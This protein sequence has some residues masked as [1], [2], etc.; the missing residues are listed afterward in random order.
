MTM[1]MNLIQ[2]AENLAPLLR[3]TAREAELNR[4][5]LDRVIDAIRESGLF[6]LMVPKQYGGFEADLDTFFEVVL[7]LSRAD[8]SMGWITGFYIEHN[9][10]LC[11]YSEDVCKKVYDG[12]NHVLAPATLNIGAGKATKVDGGYRL[13]GQW[14]WGTGIVHGSWVMAG[15]LVMDETTGPVPTFFLLPLAD[16]EPIDTWHVT[17]MCATGSWDFKIN[18]VFVPDDHALPFLQFLTATSGIAER[19]ESPLYSTPLMP[20]LGFAAALPIL[21]TAQMALTEFTNQVKQKIESNATRSGTPLQ[22]VSGVIGEVAL[23]LEAAELV[24]RNVLK[25]VMEKRNNASPTEGA[26]WLSRIAYAAFTCKDA[27]LQISEHTGASG[28]L[29]SNPIQ[30]AARDISIAANH[31]VFAK[32]ARYADV[33]KARLE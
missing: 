22:D 29:L 5:P 19:F 25:D 30:R 7:T 18:D 11:N 12:N 3:E 20:V 1:N 13:N 32:A 8:A 21:G 26:L 2:Q 14:Q 6:S 4:K 31:V 27:V 16:V 9:L 15:G 17:G 28:G 23:K 33:G 24:L 10:W